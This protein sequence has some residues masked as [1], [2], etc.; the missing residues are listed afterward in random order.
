MALVVHSVSAFDYELLFSCC[1]FICAQ[2]WLYTLICLV[3]LGTYVAYDL[4]LLALAFSYT[5]L[6]ADA[7]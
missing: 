6:H 7:I 3:L 4:F 5:F 1:P 2:H